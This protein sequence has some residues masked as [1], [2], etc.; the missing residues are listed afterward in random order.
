M[1]SGDDLQAGRTTT[2]ESTTNLLGAIPSEKDVDFN[3]IV[4]LR[5]APQPGDLA[6][7]ISL[8]GIHGVATNGGGF[9]G[10]SPGGTGVIGFGGP[11]QG[12]GVVGL[13]GGTNGSGGVGIRGVGGPGNDMIVV[14]P[15]AGIVALGGTTGD[16]LNTPRLSDG[17][18]VIAVAG[19]AR[20]AVP[21]TDAAG[22]GVFAQGA[23]AKV[24]IVNVDGVDMISG[25]NGPGAGL[26]ARGGVSTVPP[27]VP[28]SMPASAAGVIGLAGDVAASGVTS[29]ANTG[30]LGQGN[31]GPGIAGASRSDRGGVFSSAMAPQMNLL[32]LRI[33]S[34]TQI[35]V[36]ERP[37]DFL[38]TIDR[39][40][41]GTQIASLWF[42]TSVGSGGPGSGNWAKLA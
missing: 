42:C 24:S 17:A 32:P 21:T 41:R 9:M 2:A 20:K 40:E 19:G 1:S 8:D 18:G 10:A 27:L 7:N 28:V 14:S 13:G 35:G 12:T 38:V 3:G 6:P 5:V 30:V 22:V 23:D 11:N 15:G 25:P 16:D 31:A 36:K 33:K 26:V 29:G 34:P 4:I 37:G 39:D